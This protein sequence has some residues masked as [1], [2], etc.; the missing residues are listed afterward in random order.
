LRLAAVAA[1]ATLALTSS[2]E[3]VLLGV[4][5]GLAAADVATGAV[6][7]VA[8]LAL[9]VRWGATSLD[10]LAGAQAVLGPGGAVGP[11]SAMAASWCAAG[12]LVLAS[13]RGWAALAFGS[14]AGLGLAG[15]SPATGGD[16]GLRLAAAAAGVVCAVVLAR[17]TSPERGRLGALVLAGCAFVLALAS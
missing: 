15:P 7:V 11:P 3:V 16:V 4:V 10:A 12:A 1:A 14:A 13:P 5:L 9:A 17:R 6:T 8:C 2:G